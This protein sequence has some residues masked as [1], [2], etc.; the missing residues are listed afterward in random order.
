[1]LLYA[2]RKLASDGSTKD[3]LA[4]LEFDEELIDLADGAADAE[5]LAGAESAQLWIVG[6]RHIAGNH[7][8]TVRVEAKDEMCLTGR[9]FTRVGE[10]E[11]PVN[12]FSEIRF[13]CLRPH[14]RRLRLHFGKDYGW[15]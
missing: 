13:S 15:S 6:Q 1:M 8:D 5:A 4:D 7:V 11:R 10:D 12:G 3:Q 2:G 9:L 14:Q